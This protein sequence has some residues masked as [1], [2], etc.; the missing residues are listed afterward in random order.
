MSRWHKY[1]ALMCALTISLAACNNDN[2]SSETEKPE[3]VTLIAYDSFLTTE[4]IF[5][6]F[7]KATGYEV[8]VVTGGDAGELLAKAAVTTGNPEG[9]VLWGVDNTLLGRAIESGVFEQYESPGLESISPVAKALVPDHIATP[10]DTGDVCLNIDIAWF[11][12]RNLQP[13]T[14][15]ADLT[16]PEYAGLTVVPSALTSSTG[17][18]FMLASI[19]EFGEGWEQWWRE[20][21][22]N[23][24]LIVDGWTR[25]YTVEFSGS[26]GDG[27]YPIVVSYGTSP[28][29]EVLCSDPPVDT[30]A[31]AAISSGC[32]RQIE[33]AGILAGTDNRDGAEK[34]ID[35]LI[36]ETFQSDIALNMFVYPVNLNVELPELFEKYAVKP[37]SPLSLAPEEI[38]D[39]RDAWLSTWLEIVG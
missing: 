5:D 18:A 19:A 3:K 31:T 27:S 11:S 16:R 36:S 32:F 7:T 21:I 39:N 33:F 10:V 34:L 1:F 14:G 15:L 37:N 8:E 30:P 22:A 29:A 38:A 26:S 23:D 28:P 25:A 6:A 9:D 35:F 12:E 13:P 24:A 2:P 17:L 20:L 4:G